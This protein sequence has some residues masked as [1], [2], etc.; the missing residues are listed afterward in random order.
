MHNPK[1]VDL[2]QP[3]TA[4]INTI[5]DPATRTQMIVPIVLT[6]LLPV[7][8]MG[9]FAAVI[10]ASAINTDET[11]LHSWGTIFV[12]DVVVPLWG[13]PLS[14]SA[15]LMLLRGAIVAVAAFGFA[16][17][18][19]FTLRDYIFMYFNLT[20][21]IFLGG[22]GSVILGGLYWKRGTTP[23]AW[24]AMLMGSSLAFG[25]LLI[26][27]AWAGTLAP[28]LLDWFPESGFLHTHKAKFPVNGTMIYFYAMVFSVSAYV[29][30]SLF[31]P[32]KIFDMD[33]M[34]HRGVHAVASDQVIEA[35][36]AKKNLGTLLGITPEFTRRDRLIFWGTFWWQMGLW[37]IFLGGTIAGAF[38]ISIPIAAWTGFWFV[39]IWVSFVLGIGIT[40]WFVWG[41]CVDAF[42]L[43]RDLRTARI[44]QS[45]DGL[46]T[47]REM[48]H[49]HKPDG[50]PRDK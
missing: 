43:F 40:I 42:R 44:D 4:T 34:L 13:K 10:I 15:H 17:S 45:D 1:F 26:Q 33:K 19:L 32:R 47:N 36:P 18:M 46:V 6:H 25:G 2:A 16:F 29:T 11:Y 24:V 8:L 12:Q 48:A 35:S 7:G 50:L 23:A 28:L 14:P 27:Q 30:V 22:A 39:K 37:L 5:G 49:Y 41:G 21:A 20:G 3:I 9:L 38:F 31:G